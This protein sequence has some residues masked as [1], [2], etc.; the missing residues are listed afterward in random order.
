VFDALSLDARLAWLV[1]LR[2]IA[3]GAVVAVIG[4]SSGLGVVE[5]ARALLGVAFAMAAANAAFMALG[6]RGGAGSGLASAQVAADLIGLTFLLHYSG[7]SH[8]PFAFFYVFHVILASILFSPRA[9]Y[10]TAGLATLL[11]GG[12]TLADLL[13]MCPRHPLVGALPGVPTTPFALGRLAAFATTMA[14]TSYFGSTLMAGLRHKQT[15]LADSR[16]R[17]ARAEKLAAVGQLAAGIAHELNTPLGSIL[18][19]SEMARES[20]GAER[21][22]LLEDIGR[23]TKRCKEITTSLLDLS[24]KREVRLEETDAGEVVRQAVAMVQRERGGRVEIDAPAGLA[25]ARADAGA[26]GQVVA[27]VV[28]NAL[29]AVEGRSAVRVTA[30]S[31]SSGTVEIEVA[32]EGPGIAPE[33]LPRVFEPFFTTKAPGKGTGLGLPV[34]YAIIRDMK[35]EIRVDSR[36]GEGARV[37]ITLPRSGA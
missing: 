23:E 1:R 22:L 29:D 3:I 36:P 28:K 4:L 35:G 34:S 30:R 6:R 16:D 11:Y 13:G 17:L 9:A 15:E 32:D 7:G 14:A 18:V 24:R 12:L 25:K 26:L 19:A 2:W 33:D 27:N 5:G 21:S 31:G 20:E 37:T 8:N 10:L